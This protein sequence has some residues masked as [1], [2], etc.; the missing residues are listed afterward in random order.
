MGQDFSLL[1]ERTFTDASG[2]ELPYRILYPEN[3]DPEG[4][5]PLVLFLHGGGERGADNE[6][7]LVHGVENFLRPDNRERY[8]CILIAP[9]CPATDYWASAKVDR[10]NYPVGLD[11][12]YANR[13]PTTAL[14]LALALSRHTAEVEG[15]DPDRIY[16]TGLSMGGMGTFE[17]VYRAPEFFAAAAPVC[18]AGDAPAYGKLP[19]TVPFWIFHGAEDGVVSVEESRNM[20]HRLQELGADVYYTEYPGVDHNSWDYVYPSLMWFSW[21]FEQRKN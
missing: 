3:Y 15:V 20:Y 7:Q 8:P 18:G 21:L 2:R 19:A 13:P 6:S 9:Q 1:A 12:D 4:Q 16:V 10:S 17:A 5:Y 14:E 11:F